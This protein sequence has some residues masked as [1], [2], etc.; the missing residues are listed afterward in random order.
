MLR[1]T[2]NF[3]SMNNLHVFSLLIGL[4]LFGFPAFW[5]GYY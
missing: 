1:K 4:V 5:A 3:L 2:V